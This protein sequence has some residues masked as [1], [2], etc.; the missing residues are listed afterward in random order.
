M[1]RSITNGAVAALTALAL[2]G[3]W[4]TT[5]GA[6]PAGLSV[7]DNP[8]IGRHMV[9]ANGMTIYIWEDD[10]VDAN[11][12]AVSMCTGGCA[13]R[14]PPFQPAAG[15]AASD[16]LSIIEREDGMKQWAYQNVPLYHFADDEAPGDIEGFGVANDWWS[17]R[18][19]FGAQ[20]C[21]EFD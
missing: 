3:L 20:P 14:W 19:C 10:V 18:P 5:A 21:A 2:S 7:A 12:M 16:T 15:E 9:D 1:L 11:G 8:E 13:E 6:Q 17:F 4:A